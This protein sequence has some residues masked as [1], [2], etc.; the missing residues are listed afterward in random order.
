MKK[1]KH[2]DKAL[3][4]NL[5]IKTAEMERKIER[6][7]KIREVKIDELVEKEKKEK[8]SNVHTEIL[9]KKIH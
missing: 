7:E 9:K 3:I 1:E 2:K 8:N 4:M 5:R 6:L